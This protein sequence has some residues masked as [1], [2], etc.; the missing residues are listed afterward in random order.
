MTTAKLMPKKIIS[1]DSHFT[2]PGDLWLNYMEPAYKARTPHVEHGPKSDTFWCEGTEMFDLGLIHGVRYQGT[3]IE[4]QS[5]SRYADLPQTAFDPDARLKDQDFDGVSAEV[6]YPTIAMRMFSTPDTD[7]QKACFRA[8][9]NWAADFCSKHP[10]RL[11]GIALIAIDDVESAVGE[12]ERVAKKGLAGASVAVSPD[13]TLPY[14]HPT[15]DPFWAAAERLN[16]PISLHQAT[17]RR[18]T[19][20]PMGMGSVDQVLLNIW[21][22]RVLI[23][24]IYGG[25]FERFPNLRVVS[26][27]NDAGWAGNILERMDYNF[28]RWPPR[29]K[30]RGILNE[31]M[32][33]DYFR[34]ANVSM[35][36]MR[37]LTAVA[38]K[39]VIP[40][41]SIMWGSD[42][43][44]LVCTWPNSKKVIE[45]HCQYLSQEEAD[46]VFCNSA[47]KLYG[48]KA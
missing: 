2:E 8:Y 37:D 39:A 11:K 24:M 28:G 12:L 10:N 6:L 18:P 36:F 26:A 19:Y 23:A 38:A 33:S 30:A 40:V 44:H 16:M 7:Y 21:V 25:L 43:P 22:Q 32:P 14:H 13:D 35:T 5:G 15:Y 27:E 4:M 20:G 1:A 42:F 31:H 45:Q 41:E 48:I 46:K 3:K 9:N 34:S 47:A 29:N 17:E